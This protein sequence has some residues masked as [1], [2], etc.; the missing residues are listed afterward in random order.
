MRKRGGE[1][2]HT[3]G[4]AVQRQWQAYRPL[5]STHACL[6]LVGQLAHRAATGF[7]LKRLLR[8]INAAHQ[9]FGDT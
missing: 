1:G 7:S 9:K 5:F 8:V 4:G 3:V 2:Q 6:A